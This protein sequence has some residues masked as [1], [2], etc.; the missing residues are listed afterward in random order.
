MHGWAH[1]SMKRDDRARG[2]A[3]EGEDSYFDTSTHIPVGVQRG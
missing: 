2:V 3:T 1:S